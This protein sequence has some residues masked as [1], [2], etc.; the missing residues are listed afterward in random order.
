MSA[1]E[2]IVVRLPKDEVTRRLRQAAGPNIGLFDTLSSITGEV[3]LLGGVTDG[4]FEL[5]RRRTYPNAFAP[6]MTGFLDTAQQGTKLRYEFG[7]SEEGPVLASIWAVSTVGYLAALALGKL[8]W[9][10]RS[11]QNGIVVTILA[12]AGLSLLGMWRLARSERKD[13]KDLVASLFRGYVV[14]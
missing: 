4:T 10:V 6:R 13:L 7:P 11:Q 9:G 3:S 12:F 14:S 5:A 2:P 1:T 8:P